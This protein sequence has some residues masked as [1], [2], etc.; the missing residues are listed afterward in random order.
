MKNTDIFLPSEGYDMVV[1]V[2]QKTINDQIA[3]LANPDIGIIKT[4]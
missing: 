3:I 2:T 1:S 4:S